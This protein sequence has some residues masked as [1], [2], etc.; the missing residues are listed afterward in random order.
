MLK[1]AEKIIL[2][3]FTLLT[4]LHLSAILLESNQ[5]ADW[6]KLL[7]LPCLLVFFVWRFKKSKASFAI[8]LGLLFSFFG[9]WALIYDKLEGDGYFMIG[10][11][12]FLIAH[13]FYIL[14]FKKIA[15]NLESKNKLI[16]GIIFLITVGFLL[17]IIPS[18]HGHLRTAV[19]VYALVI[20]IMVISAYQVM[21]SSPEKS[22]RLLFA[23]ACL[24]MCSDL[25]L[26]LSMFKWNIS[27]ST[28][29]IVIMSTY[30]LAQFLIASQS[31][32]LVGS[33]S[34]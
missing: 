5:L 30:L 6:S 31:K 4:V 24:F 9:D 14:G 2:G 22:G 11:G 18:V 21:Y 26:A 3:F 8:A 15:T 33:D 34:D 27:T 25:V 10:L 17:Y 16:P 7:L 28:L 29:S 13:I 12:A 20:C 1:S 23:G 19:T 32:M